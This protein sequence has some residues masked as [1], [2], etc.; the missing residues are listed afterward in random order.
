MRTFTL[1]F[2]CFAFTSIAAQE[3]KPTAPQIA[4]RI[5]LD[6]TIVTRDMSIHFMEVLEDS[7]CPEGVVC[8]WAGQ[9]RVKLRISGPELEEQEVEL[10]LGITNRVD[11]IYKGDSFVL[12]AADLAPYPTSKDKGNRKYTLLVVDKK[13][14][15]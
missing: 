1:I 10:T 5:D 4:I 15:D 8:V 3:D 12:K 9:A 13:L 6:E 2:L 7:R 11:V 14:W